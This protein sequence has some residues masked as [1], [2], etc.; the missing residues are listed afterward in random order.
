[1]VVGS[2]R[3]YEHFVPPAQAEVLRNGEKDCPLESVEFMDCGVGPA[4]CA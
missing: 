1:V 4:G 3:L 2:D